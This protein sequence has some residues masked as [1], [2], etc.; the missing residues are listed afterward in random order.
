[1]L[2]HHWAGAFSVMIILEYANL[3]DITKAQ[4]RS[5][6][7]SEAKY[8]DEEERDARDDKFAALAGN[9]MHTDAIVVENLK[10]RK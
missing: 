2:S 3:Q 6:K 9:G 4:D 5:T 7:L 8:P 1:M 10:L